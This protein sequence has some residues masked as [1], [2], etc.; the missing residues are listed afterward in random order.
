M[1]HTAATLTGGL[2]ALALAM[3]IGRF[4]YTAILPAMQAQT[5]LSVADAGWLASLNFLGYFLGAVAAAWVP[6]G[7]PRVWTFRASLAL[8]VATTAAMGLFDSFAMWQAARFLSGLAS[9]GVFILGVAMALDALTRTGQERWAGWLYTGVGGGIAGSGLFVAAS[10]LTPQGGGLSHAGQWLALGTI[11]AALALAPLL[12]MRDDPPAAANPAK[13]AGGGSGAGAAAGSGVAWAPLLLLT[14]AY[15][16]EGG[17]YIVTGTFLPAMMAA[18]PAAAAWAGWAWTLAGLAAIP[19]G[20]AWAAAARRLG[21]WGALIAAHL[22]QAAGVVLPLAGGGPAGA[23]SAIAFGLTFIGIVA[24]SFVLG[25][26]LSGG[27][28]TRV[29]GLLTAAY[30]LGQILGPLAAARLAGPGG[31]YGRALSAAAVA[32]L[33]AALLLALGALLDRPARNP[34]AQEPAR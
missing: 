7:R 2:A 20:L 31:D 27:A 14:A 26:R 6:R 15:F 21:V 22:V 16:L 34:Q 19:S 5:G 10:G 32:V 4:A 25:R 8:S 29:I 23:L 3:G 12:A 28:S 13:A 18:D 24:Q 17:G 11:A 1:R 30:G 33:A 9:A